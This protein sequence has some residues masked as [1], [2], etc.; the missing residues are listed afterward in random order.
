MKFSGSGLEIR[1]YGR[2]D[3]SRWSR[4]TLYP[5]KLALTSPISGG[6]SVGIVRS[7]TQATEFLRLINTI[8]TILKQLKTGFLFHNLW[9][10][11][12]LLMWMQQVPRNVGNR[13]LTR[14]EPELEVAEAVRAFNNAN[15]RT[16]YA[17]NYL[18]IGKYPSQQRMIGC[19]WH[20]N[21]NLRSYSWS[22]WSENAACISVTWLSA[23]REQICAMY[24]CSSVCC[25]SP[26]RNV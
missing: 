11:M 9:S 24:E 26:Q 12:L 13:L 23:Q 16:E 21:E 19:K 15:R 20:C 6:R 14:P 4:S 3:P 2:R 22:L 17:R 10:V 8:Y 7:L 5:Q 18:P 1:V 25:D